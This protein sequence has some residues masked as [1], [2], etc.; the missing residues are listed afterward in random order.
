MYNKRKDE[1]T[2]V[3]EERKDERKEKKGPT[4]R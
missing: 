1:S 3:I 2:A 4:S